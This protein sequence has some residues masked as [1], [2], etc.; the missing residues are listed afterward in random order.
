[1]DGGGQAS[2]IG[3]DLSAFMTDS[4]RNLIFFVVLSVEEF[5]STEEM[6]KLF[7]DGSAEAKMGNTERKKHE[8]CE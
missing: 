5:L 2:V 6:R 3:I 4:C 8:L 7:S 1:V